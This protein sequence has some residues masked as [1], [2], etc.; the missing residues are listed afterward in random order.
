MDTT[1]KEKAL[2]AEA[3]AIKLELA[4]YPKWDNIGRGL[5]LGGLAVGVLEVFSEI[6][7]PFNWWVA[8]LGSVIL[9]IVNGQK[10]LSGKN[11]RRVDKEIEAL[12]NLKTL[13]ENFKST[14]E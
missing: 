9:W 11:K 8:L 2:I 10:D 7:I 14:H 13:K 5:V 1:D 3:E 6:N 4:G 12:V